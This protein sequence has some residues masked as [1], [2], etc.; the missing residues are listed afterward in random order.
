MATKPSKL[1]SLARVKRRRVHLEGYLLK[2]WIPTLEGF[3]LN[4]IR[5]RVT[6]PLADEDAFR[7]K[8]LAILT[9][10][11]K[12]TKPQYIVEALRV[13][14]LAKEPRAIAMEVYTALQ[15]LERRG[16]AVHE[17]RRGWLAATTA[18]RGEAM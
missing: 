17:S 8:V 11:L 7:G 5:L 10:A 4:G 16:L 9:K 15:K 2:M 14:G 12:P 13:E 1:N 18:E 3:P 6:D